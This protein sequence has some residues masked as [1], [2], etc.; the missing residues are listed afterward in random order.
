MNEE[1]IIN[2]FLMFIDEGIHK[3]K[4]HLFNN[5]GICLLSNKLRSTI[6]NTKYS[7]HEFN[8]L[9]YTVYQNNIIVKSNETKDETSTKTTTQFTIED[10][11]S[12][13]IIDLNIK[14]NAGVL[15]DYIL[16]VT[17]THKKLSIF[18]NII[19]SIK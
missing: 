12:E 18:Q 17:K 7:I 1:E 15:L 3:G 16:D 10:I 13:K 6:E 4:Q 9:R 19:K 11:E 2:Y 14:E 8:K 5:Y